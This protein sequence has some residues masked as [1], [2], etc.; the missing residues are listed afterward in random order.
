[1][2][3]RGSLRR[4]CCQASIPD[5]RIYGGIPMKSVPK[6]QMWSKSQQQAF[7]KLIDIGETFFYAEWEGAGLRPR[8]DPLVVGPSGA[9]K[10]HLI[11]AV[12]EQLALPVLRITHGEWIVAGSRSSSAHTTEKVRKF[13]QQNE[14]GIVHMDELDKARAGFQS[15]WTISV[16]AEIFCLIDRVEPAG[17]RQQDWS[18]ELLKRLSKDIWFIGTG[19]WQDLWTK[20]SAPSIG[21]GGA[22]A[23]IDPADFTAD[24]HRTR[25]IPDE[26]LRR[27]CSD[28]ICL[29]SATPDEYRQ[30]ARHFGLVK[31]ARKLNI[32]LDYE[33]GASGNLG[34]RWLEETYASLLVTAWKR[35]RRDILPERVQEVE[36]ADMESSDEIPF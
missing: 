22:T 23:R 27:F 29:N 35:G 25:L 11:R 28:I 16:F 12:A 21:F 36:I 1:M 4:F 18:P 32:K 5:Q 34:A 7:K 10:T 33:N 24:I 31:I 6:N 15:E 26:L 8:L 2:S 20:Q 30:A 19:T 3:F 9:G 17:G 14:R 13:I